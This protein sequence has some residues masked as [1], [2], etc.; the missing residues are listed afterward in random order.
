MYVYISV[1]PEIKHRGRG[2]LHL[3]PFDSALNAVDICGEPYFSHLE[4]DT[5]KS[6]N[7]T[8]VV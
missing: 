2:V 7:F 6:W 3:E 1:Y 5:S 4:M 8:V